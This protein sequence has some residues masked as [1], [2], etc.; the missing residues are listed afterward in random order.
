M[1]LY[2]A[3]ILL[4][5]KNTCQVTYTKEGNHLTSIPDDIPLNVQILELRKNRITHLTKSDFDQFRNLE[6]IYLALNVIEK[7]DEDF[8]NASI[9]SNLTVL[10]IKDNLIE[11]IPKLVG[12]ESL[13]YLHLSQNKL[14]EVHFGQLDSLQEI[15]IDGN[16]L[17]S[18]PNLT[19]ELPSLTKLILHKNN[20]A[21]LP[22]GYFAKLPALKELDLTSNL[23]V[24]ITIGRL[25]NLEN[26]TLLDN[27][28]TTM[29][30]FTHTMPALETLLL[31]KNPITDISP[32]YFDQTPSLKELKLNKARITTFDCSGLH[33]LQ[34]LYL[35]KTWVS[36]FPNITECF[37]SLVVF[38]IQHT[39][40]RISTP[41]IDMALVF[42]SSL[43]RKVSTS[44]THV[45]FRNTHI[46]HVPA[47]FL[48][49]VPSLKF[50]D[51]ANI[52]LTEM[53]DI[54]TNYKYVRL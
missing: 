39:Y 20:I 27:K 25:G 7:V 4:L 15:F 14:Q 29:P 18:M 6:E 46:Q 23:F 49:A 17:S 54:S 9:H 21:E 43:Q 5:V 34:K 10:S 52:K 51:M 22:I 30:A 35:D 40:D 53:P 2:L 45:Y 26:L 16:N 48:H 42:G 38:S 41:G 8:L 19:K 24:Q 50:L 32:G 3:S 44:L 36:T 33:Q 31:S 12:L 28:L 1:L 47:W 11:M 13:K 37:S